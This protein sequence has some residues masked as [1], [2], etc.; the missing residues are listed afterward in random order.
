[1]CS[2]IEQ[3][4]FIPSGFEQT[5][6]QGFFFL[7]FPYFFEKRRFWRAMPGG[8]HVGG[9]PPRRAR[10]FQKKKEEK[11]TRNI[12]LDRSN[13]SNLANFRETFF[14]DLISRISQHFGIY[15][16]C[17]LKVA[18]LRIYFD[19]SCS[20]FHEIIIARNFISS[21]NFQIVSFIFQKDVI[22]QKY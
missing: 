6:R 4:I 8:P 2:I 7:I 5:S 15:R 19:E 1:M 3:I 10:C 20:E 18:V 21:C 14:A 12:L 13:L 17:L 22:L 16:N 11:K 9:F